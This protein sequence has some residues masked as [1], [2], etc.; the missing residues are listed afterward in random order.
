MSLVDHFDLPD[1]AWWDDFYSP[2]E[3]QIEKL[4]SKYA[5]DAEALA[6]P[7]EVAKEPAMHRRSGHHYGYN[8]DRVHTVLDLHICLLQWPGGQGS[9]VRIPPSRQSEGFAGQP[10]AGQGHCVVG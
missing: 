5:G 10:P 1:E 7:D 2:M 9:W 8:F 4:R 3:R 6:A